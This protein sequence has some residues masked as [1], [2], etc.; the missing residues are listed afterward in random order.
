MEN[1]VN[2]VIPTFNRESI[3]GDAI[4][5]ALAQDH[6]DLVVTVVDDGSSDQTTEAVAGYLPHP[7]FRYIS[8]MHNVGTAQA[9]NVAIALNDC[10]FITFHDSDDFPHSNKI[11]TQV[12][13]AANP[14]IEAHP[15]L[16]WRLSGIEP[17]SRLDVDL[18]VSEHT[19]VRADGSRHHIRRALSLVDD[20]FPNLQMA[21]GVPGDWILI[22]CGLFRS[23]VFRKVGGFRNCI[24]ED[25]EIRN[26][27]IFDGGVLWL[28]PQI[29]LTKYE[30][31]DSLTVQGETNYDSER[32]SR[33]RASIWSDASAF[34]QGESID[35]VVMDLS[36]VRFKYLSDDLGLSDVPM[37]PASRRNMQREIARVRTD[38]RE[39]Q[40]SA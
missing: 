30:C 8:L 35:P 31:E 38:S 13:V 17:G 25:R 23:S 18:V 36:D 9:K 26:R 20:V 5:A 28:V 27:L 21:A 19:L 33:D 6:E 12:A 37:T 16:N 7:R 10:R 22:N 40:C 1:S 2:V 29:L 34:R 15:I 39:F 14:D 32:R 24:E 4:E 11:S 3:I